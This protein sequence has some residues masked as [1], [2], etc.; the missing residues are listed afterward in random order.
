MWIARAAAAQ[1]PNA[2]GSEGRGGADGGPEEFAAFVASF[3]TPVENIDEL[4]TGIGH[5]S[6]SLFVR[7]VQRKHPCAALVPTI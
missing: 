6:T 7:T 4:V 1:V 3:D 5:G 2:A